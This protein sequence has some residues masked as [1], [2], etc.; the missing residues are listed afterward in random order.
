MGPPSDRDVFAA[1]CLRVAS[2][3]NAKGMTLE[4]SSEPGSHAVKISGNGRSVDFPIV[5]DERTWLETSVEQAFYSVLVD[6]RGWSAAI[7]DDASLATLVDDVEREEVPLI[8]KD[9]SEE[10]ERISK[11]AEVAGGRTALE[12]L[13]TS[14]ELAN[15]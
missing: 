13:L 4:K 1:R 8:R 6:A 12:E 2:A 11:L 5:T 9:L 10:L 14:V 7:V 3:A 15:V